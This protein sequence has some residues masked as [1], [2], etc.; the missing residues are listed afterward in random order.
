MQDAIEIADGIHRLGDA[1]PADGRILWTGEGATGWAPVNC[2]LVVDGRDALLI[3]TG[4]AAHRPAILRQL[5]RL[6]AGRV[7]RLRIFLTRQIEFDS[8]GNAAAIVDRSPVESVHGHL[9][10]PG[11]LHFEGPPGEGMEMPI[12]QI[13]TTVPLT[14]GARE[15][16]VFAPPLRLLQTAWLLD[17]RTGTLFCSD[18]FGHMLLDDP[19]QPPLVEHADV[20]PERVEAAL[21]AKSKWLMEADVT[22]VLEELAAIFEREDV[23]TLAPGIGCVLRGPD[24][25]AG[26]V[27][28]VL[29]AIRRAPLGAMR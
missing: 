19:A 13:D 23:R 9:P 18:A 12:L 17:R 4:V 22:Y 25:V 2:Y 15:L 11:W 16:D 8:F 29:D 28:L 3:D 24:V 6:V 5:K 10:W 14:V 20:S 21:L 27:E 1:S 7:D 26:H